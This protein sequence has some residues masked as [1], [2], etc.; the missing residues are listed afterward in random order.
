MERVCQTETGATRLVWT[1]KEGFVLESETKRS[2]TQSLSIDPKAMDAIV[3]AWPK[4]RENARSDAPARIA[5][6]ATP[7]PPASKA[8]RT[9]T[10]SPSSPPAPPPPPAGR[11]L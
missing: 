1:E 4:F 10:N 11:L 5:A 8:G 9:A 2:G 3:A 7:S 6:P